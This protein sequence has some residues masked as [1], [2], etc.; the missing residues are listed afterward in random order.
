MIGE[1]KGTGRVA[2]RNQR[3]SI[4]FLCQASLRFRMRSKGWG[5]QVPTLTG[6]LSPG[7]QNRKLLQRHSSGEGTSLRFAGLRWM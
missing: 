5:I 7:Q 3:A 1:K 2:T 4:R 6:P